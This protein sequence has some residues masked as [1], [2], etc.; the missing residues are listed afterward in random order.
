[1]TSYCEGRTGRPQRP[2]GYNNVGSFPMQHRP[3]PRA[4]PA[5]TDMKHP[6][7]ASQDALTVTTSATTPIGA[8]RKSRSPVLTRKTRPTSTR[9]AS[10]PDNPSLATHRFPRIYSEVV[11]SEAQASMS[12]RQL[13]HQ[14]VA[15]IP[16]PVPPGAEVA[17]RFRL[18]LTRRPSYAL[19]RHGDLCPGSATFPHACDVS[20][21]RS[22]SFS[23]DV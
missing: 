13:H 8:T 19:R 1:M 22:T 15:T 18:P 11:S 3:L 10:P 17:D 7:P 6:C 14:Y 2:V 4:P 12:A 5:V 9:P 23:T 16:D 21:C 20:S